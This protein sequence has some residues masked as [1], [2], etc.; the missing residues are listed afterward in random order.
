M[1]VFVSS[2]GIERDLDLDLDAICA[3][4]DDHPD[5]NIAKM[6]MAMDNGFRM[7]DMKVLASF[8]GISDLKAF[9]QEGFSLKVLMEAVQKSSIMG[10]TDSSSPTPEEED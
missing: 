4:E 3:Y 7:T 6:M 2:K 5:W 1:T 9:L 10:F 8:F